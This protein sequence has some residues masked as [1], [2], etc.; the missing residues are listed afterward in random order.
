MAAIFIYVIHAL[1]KARNESTFEAQKI[2]LS[3]I[4]LQLHGALLYP[5]RK[6]QNHSAPTRLGLFLYFW[7]FLMV[8]TK[9]I[10]KQ[11]LLPFFDSSAIVLAM[12]TPWAHVSN[13]LFFSLQYKLLLKKKKRGVTYCSWPCS[14]SHLHILIQ[15]GLDS[16]FAHL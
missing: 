13:F 1:W 11:I 7:E 12:G 10:C 4:Q 3:K 15:L 2:P 16:S 9:L 8:Q 5:W 14:G 6:S